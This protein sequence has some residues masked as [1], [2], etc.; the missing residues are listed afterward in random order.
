[1]VRG[2]IEEFEIPGCHLDIREEP[3]FGILAQ[4]TADWLRILAEPKQPVGGEMASY[5]A[6][7]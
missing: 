4:K 2:K 5:V 7:G 3:S 1:M 6:Q